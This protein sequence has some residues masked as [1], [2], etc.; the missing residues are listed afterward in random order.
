MKSNKANTSAN[1]REGHRFSITLTRLREILSLMLIFVVI[2]LIMSLISFNREDSSWTVVNHYL[3]A[4]SGGLVGAWLADVL[5]TCF[6]YMAW[7]FVLLLSGVLITLLFQRGQPLQWKY[8]LIYLRLPSFIIFLFSCC[9]L[10]ILYLNL[11]EHINAPTYAGGIVGSLVLELFL[12]AFGVYGSTLF[13]IALSVLGFTLL[14]SFSWFVFMELLGK[15][16]LLMARKVVV[17]LQ[18]FIAFLIDILLKVCLVLFKRKNLTVQDKLCSVSSKKEPVI[19]LP[20]RDKPKDGTAIPSEML[21]HPLKKASLSTALLDR[22]RDGALPGYSVDEQQRQA[23]LL[24]EKLKDFGIDAV[25][26][27]IQPGPVVTRFE[28]Q[29]APGLKV[30]KISGLATD[31]ARSLS[32][33]RVRVVEVIPGKSVVGIEVPNRHRKMVYLSEVVESTVFANA[34][35]PLSLVLG[36]DI[37]G[38]AMVADLAKMPHLL[39]AGTTGSGKSVGVN[40]MILSLLYKASPAEVRLIM[41]DPKMLELSVYEGIPHLLTPV[42]TD[43]KEAA[44]AL[45]WCVIEME[46]RYKLMSALGVRNITGFNEKIR[47]IQRGDIVSNDENFLSSVEGQKTEPFEKLPFIVVVIDEFADMMMI[48]GKKVEE[49]IAR[50]AQKARA[51]GIHLILATQRPSVDVITGLI[52]ANVPARISFQVSSKID[53]RTIIDQSGAEQ[54]LGQGDMLYLPPGSGLPVRVHGAFVSDQEV[55]RVV[56][57]WK[58]RGEPEYIEE[59]LET[60]SSGDDGSALSGGLYD[61]EKDELYDE[62]VAFVV[63]TRKSSFSAVQR[64]FRIGY[65]RAANI[66]EAMEAAGIV[67]SPG[68]NGVRD[69]LVSP[70]SE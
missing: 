66:V 12:P 40:A 61:A 47:Q 59:I 45:R 19:P 46:R 36:Q 44:G 4:N 29:P 42:V 52:K 32:V 31:L 30:S 43:M 57:D 62:A 21:A 65:N 54:L 70:T 6:G 48:V 26:V 50:I 39:V 34:K 60:K 51:A 9:A 8:S 63:Q 64:Q 68:S 67:S 69:I 13:L 58:S 55:H 10:S 14:T 28:I 22:P 20:A 49:L 16:L 3:P 24:E 2:Y 18:W 33:V 7:M 15:I 56:A 37:S 23:A 5:F 53:S 38:E 41:V 35:S 17:S 11:P 1:G 25:V 27:A